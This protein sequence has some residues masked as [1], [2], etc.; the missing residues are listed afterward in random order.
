MR[1]EHAL[2][3]W[4][5]LDARQDPLPHMVPIPYKTEG[6]RY[7]CCGIRI[8]GGAAFIDA[9]LSNLQSLIDGEN[10]VTRLELARHAVKK[11]PGYKSGENAAPEAEVCYIRLHVRGSQGCRAS[12]VFDR[13]LHKATERYADTIGAVGES[14]GVI[15]D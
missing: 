3:H 11:Q 8:D 13:H 12:F 6:S 7:G 2:K 10:N 15:A 4:R 1:K 14:L 5:G 9:V